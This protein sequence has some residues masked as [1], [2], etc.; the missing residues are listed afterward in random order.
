MDKVQFIGETSLQLLKDGVS[1][2]LDPGKT[3]AHEGDGLPCAG[4]FCPEDQEMVVAMGAEYSLETYAHEYCH[5]TQWMDG[6]MVLD[7]DDDQIW[8]WL[9]GKDFPYSVVERSVRSSQLLE[10]DNERRTVE[11]IQKY[12]LPIDLTTYRQKSNAYAL[13]YNVVLK[14]RRWASTTPVYSVPE[15]YGKLPGDRILSDEEIMEDVPPWFYKA[16]VPRMGLPVVTPWWRKAL[17][18]FKTPVY[19]PALTQN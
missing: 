11:L 1:V 18:G 6:R 16:V 9:A 7:D 5:Y 2:R 15:I 3:V 10:S 8:E 17:R 19:D 13:F 4:W 12:E 14:T